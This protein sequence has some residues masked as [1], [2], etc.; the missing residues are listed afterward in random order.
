MAPAASNDIQSVLLAIRALGREPVIVQFPQ[1]RPSPHSPS[2]DAIV[3]PVCVRQGR[4]TAAHAL[5][6][7]QSRSPGTGLADAPPPHE[8]GERHRLAWFCVI[9]TIGNPLRMANSRSLDA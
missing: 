3:L 5:V 1:A 4:R 6:A 7:F 9:S 2:G 8:T